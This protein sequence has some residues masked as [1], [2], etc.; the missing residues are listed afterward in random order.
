[1][2]ISLDFDGTVV[3][4]AHPAIGKD[5]GAVPVLKDLIRS[6]HKL[7]LNTMRFGRC[8]QDAIDW[9]EYNGI[10]L[11]GVNKTPGQSN[12]TT[13]PKVHADIYIDDKSLGIPLVNDPVNGQY[14]DWIRVRKLLMKQGVI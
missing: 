9:F 11:Y 8:L 14:V 2:I 3:T 1:M 4:E 6:G 10:K 5:I 13:S 12:W 7:V